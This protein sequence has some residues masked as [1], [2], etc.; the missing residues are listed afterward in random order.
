MPSRA[1]FAEAGTLVFRRTFPPITRHRLALYCGGSGDQN[2][3]HVDS[4]YAR[5]SGYDDVFVHGMLVMAYL[6]RALTDCL[7][8]LALRS[9][10]VRFVSKTQVHAAITCEAL[11]QEASAD[12]IHLKLVARDESGDVKLTGT[13]IVAPDAIPAG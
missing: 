2:P 9:Y 13:A 11:V 7:P 3:I 6:G 5:A 12:G 1:A 4:D 8:P 10:G